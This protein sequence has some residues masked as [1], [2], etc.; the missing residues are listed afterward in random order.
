MTRRDAYLDAMLRELG[1][2]YYSSLHG[3]AGKA[4]V[5]RAL[6]SV[7]E[8]IGDKL[9]AHPAAA[10]CAPAVQDGSGASWPHRGSWHNRVEDV[11]TTSVVTVNRITS[12]KRIASLLAEYKIS[13][14]PVLAGGRHVAGVVS[15]AD[16]LGAR[17][18]NAAARHRWLPSWRHRHRNTAEELMTS[19][20]ITIPP[21]ATIAAAGR[22]MN[23]HHARRLPVVDSRGV[24]IGIVSRRDLLSVFLRPDDQ[25]AR[26]IGEIL[27]E[28]LPGGPTG[29]QV[30]VRD[31]VVTLTGEPEPAA[32]ADLI[33][34]AV[35]LAWDVDAV[36][37][38]VD[39]TGPA[40]VGRI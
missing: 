24:L 35:R 2:A 17:S 38:V 39:K 20:A 18:W 19:P 28:L 8:Q 22:L 1:A 11:M 12:Y 5:A 40:A 7:A 31:G 9:I 4:D 14:M 25:I 6:G 10:E 16:L 23:A 33:P 13:G 34:V 30:S 27:T 26:Q 15:E 37:D 29:I 3:K 36:V 21:D 32:A